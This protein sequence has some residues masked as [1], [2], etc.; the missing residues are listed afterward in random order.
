MKIYEKYIQLKKIDNTKKYLFKSGNFYIFLD[1]DARKISN[2]TT[3]KLTT[4]G[5]TIKCGFPLSSKDKY[6]S[7]LN[8]IGIEIVLVENKDMITEQIND[9]K[10]DSLSKEQLILIIERYKECL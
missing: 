1:D 4:F 5:N 2:I 10:L 8:N 9:I 7:I 3:L 6:L